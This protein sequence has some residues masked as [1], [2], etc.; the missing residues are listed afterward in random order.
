[1]IHD[2]L[3]LLTDTLPVQKIIKPVKQKISPRKEMVGEIFYKNILAGLKKFFHERKFKKGVLG[4]SGGVDSSLTLKLAVDALGKEN[5]SAL[6]MPELGLTK[7]E[8]ID[9]A[10]A[11]AAYFGAVTYYQPI[12]TFLMDYPMLPWKPTKLS[13]MNVK[14]RI[15]MNLLYNFANSENA[16]VLGTSNRSEILLGYGTKFGD[17]ACDI[18][19]IG[20][21]YKTEVIMV[22]D[23]VGLPPEIVHKVPSAELSEGQTDEDELGASYEDMDKVLMKLNLGLEGC[24]EHGLPAPLVHKVF[25][26]VK[27]NK[28][29]SETPFVIPVR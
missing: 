8:N 23:F 3:S 1:M 21:L 9:H 18:E 17:M 27:A 4:L 19:V 16:L 24:I 14:A 20:D 26:L 10:K 13:M 7:Q 5:V 22:A 12:N 25:G 29:K 15:R 6:I 11:L 2:Q 28:H